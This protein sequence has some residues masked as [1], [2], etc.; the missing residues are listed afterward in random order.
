MQSLRPRMPTTPT[1]S[2]RAPLT[3]LKLQALAV[4]GAFGS[5][6]AALQGGA[7]ANPV[8][9]TVVNGQATFNAAGK[10]L[11]ITNTPGAVINWQSFSIGASE[12][13]KFQQQSA[14]SA[15]LNRVVG[16]D[17][18]S[19]L[20][21]LISNGKVFLINPNGIVFGQGARIDVAGLVAST[22]HISTE[23]FLNGKLK[24]QAG[25]VQGT[26][27]NQGSINAAPGGTI[28]LVGKDVSNSGIIQAPNGQIILAAGTT[29]EVIDT[30]T[31]GVKVVFTADANKAENLGT[32]TGQ[33]IN[34]AGALLRNKGIINANQ[35]SRDAQGRIVLSASKSVTLESGSTITANSQG[36][37]TAGGSIAIT[38]GNDI[39]VEGNTLT[40]A[41]GSAG[42]GGT[43]K[44]TT[45]ETGVKITV[46]AGALIQ[47]NGGA[48]ATASAG[49]PNSGQ[50]GGF[51]T[52]QATKGT[53]S[54]AGNLEARGVATPTTA[55]TTPGTAVGA[56]LGANLNDL[57][58]P[59]AGGTVQVLGQNVALSGNATVDASGTD[60][61]GTILIGGDYRGKNPEIQNAL[62]TLIDRN[63]ILKAD[64][65]LKGDGGKVI[66]WADNATY[67]TGSLLARG[68][69]EGGDGGFAEVSGK[70]FLYFSPRGSVDLSAPNGK[71][72]TLLLD[73][74]DITIVSGPLDIT[75]VS[76]PADINGDGSTG[77]DISS[78]TALNTSGA[79]G[80][81][82][83]V[84]TN[85]ALAGVLNNADVTLQASSNITVNAAINS[86]SGLSLTADRT[87]TL[88][89]NT[90]DLL[91]SISAAGSAY[92]L[93]LNFSANSSINITTGAQLLTNGGVV[94]I[95][96]GIGTFI[97]GGTINTGA[98]GG[99][100]NI[101]AD[102]AS[103]LSGSLLNTTGAGVFIQP[104]TAS[105]TINL[106]S[107]AGGL[108]LS[109]T[110][111]GTV[112]SASLTIG[113]T[114]QTGDINAKGA[115]TP[116]GLPALSLIQNPAAGGKIYL[117]DSGGS[118]ALNVSAANLV[119]SAGTGGIVANANNAVNELQTSGTV[120]MDTTGSMGTGTNQIQYSGSAT[121]GLITIGA[122]A[123]PSSVSMTG[124]A[125][126]LGNVTASGD[127]SIFASGNVIVSGNVNAGAGQISM[128]ADAETSPD[129]VGNFSLAA[130]K[131]ISTSNTTHVT[132]AAANFT[133][134][135]AVAVSISGADIDLQGAVAPGSG[136]DVSLLVSKAGRTVGLGAATGALSL[137][138]TELNNV[139][140][141][142]AAG[143]GFLRVGGF[144]SGAVNVSGVN[145]T[146]RMAIVSGSTIDD[147]GTGAAITSTS[148]LGLRSAG[149]IGAA[150][151]GSDGLTIA[152]PF[153][154][155]GN[156]GGADAA[157]THS[158]AGALT[159]RR[160]VTGGVGNITL[161]KPTGNISFVQD[162]GFT[163]TD[164][165]LTSGSLSISAAAGAITMT[166]M[167]ITAGSISLFASGSITGNSVLNT[168]AANG[169]IN[170]S[171]S[172]IGASGGA[173]RINV[174]PGT[175][176][177]RATSLS[178]GVSDGVFLNQTVGNLV[179]SRFNLD[180]AGTNPIEVST[181]GGNIVID[182]PFDGPTARP[183]TLEVGGSGSINFTPSGNNQVLASQLNLVGAGSGNTINFVSGTTT[184][185]TPVNTNLPI[186]LTGGATFA[187]GTSTLAGAISGTG[188][189]TIN[190]SGINV[191][192]TAGFSVGALN[193]SDGTINFGAGAPN[194]GSFTQTGGAITGSGVLSVGTAFNQTGGAISGPFSD[195]NILQAA[196]NLSVS[197]MSAVNTINLSA[198]SGAITDANG[199]GVNNLVAPT[200]NLKAATGIDIDT[201]ATTVNLSATA[202]STQNVRVPN[203]L[204][205]NAASTG[206]AINVS[207]TGA[208]AL[209]AVSTVGAL[210]LS[211]GTGITQTAPLSVASVNITGGAGVTLNNVGNAIGT[212][213]LSTG[214][215]VVALHSSTNITLAAL[216]GSASTATISSAGTISNSG[217]TTANG[218]V[219][220]SGTGVANSGII[221]GTGVQIS[222]GTGSLNT[223][224]INGTTGAVYL[225]G[226][227]LSIAGSIIAGSISGAAVTLAPFT[228]GTAVALGSGGGYMIPSAAFGSITGPLTIS[229]GGPISINSGIT[230][231]GSLKLNSPST[232]SIN[233]NVTASGVLNID[234]TT[235]G[236]TGAT[237]QG[238]SVALSASGS[239]ALTGS[240]SGPAGVV[241]TSGNIS[242]S[243]PGISYTA[244]SGNGAYINAVAG[245]AILTVDSC[246]GCTTLATNPTVSSVGSYASLG[247]TTVS[248]TPGTNAVASTTSSLINQTIAS[249]TTATTSTSTA[250]NTSTSASS[251]TISSTNLVSSSTTSSTSTTPFTTTSSGSAGDSFN[252]FVS[253]SGSTTTTSRTT[254]PSGS[255]TSTTGSTTT[256][257]SGTN[258]ATTDTTGGT[259]PGSTTGDDGTSSQQ[260][261]QGKPEEKPEAKPDAQPQTK[262]AAKPQPK[263]VLSC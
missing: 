178:T 243:A 226:D 43:I 247:V 197:A 144:T 29:V 22:S 263:K 261:P 187:T 121:P 222:S 223:G 45:T 64:A 19:I 102:N 160:L 95:N 115:A 245:S 127:V 210:N 68:G 142:G 183:I 262:P 260:Q 50:A 118:T 111:L 133:G 11:T 206:G 234:P 221:T 70:D 119:L 239:I 135:S 163:A 92:K 173:N 250:T 46:D 14:S 17:P 193:V 1:P 108:D 25:V 125:F 37:G 34:I 235:I 157:L 233:A 248:F 217:T 154:G 194:I 86:D 259:N 150:S 214:S 228:A 204:T 15:V 182:T 156:T 253:G 252:S 55:A 211:A 122:N 203:A 10:T 24:F 48:N 238:S 38:A 224:T 31:P 42:P 36:N 171:G 158:G 196:G 106:G 152:V 145:V 170:V 35:V 49:Q 225:V 249:T 40:Q 177:V 101:I 190:G 54:V 3:R 87:L 116:T 258:T 76:G 240:G 189:I 62:T 175:G 167:P 242:M 97:N 230:Y 129:G 218:L 60:G 85:A 236:I 113:A 166:A 105:R 51:I 255:T 7:L 74:L 107:G 140:V 66:V 168:S 134:L 220:F 209:G 4:A 109:N 27:V 181:S 207:A 241:A 5:L 212:A 174:N 88:Q 93:N 143:T 32:L 199:A 78:A 110:E 28:L 21:Q 58:A 69:R 9:P 100:I 81:V 94:T 153:L 246:I 99:N 67:F 198:T 71:R 61:G 188:T 179:G 136:G 104:F 18:S 130:G 2:A 216:S 244:G 256:S 132:D 12:I 180:P 77:D 155:I 126:A 41:N 30:T 47:A 90:I 128:G 184:F 213:T 141:S 57:P 229:T 114:G 257:T 231:G 137:S 159:V 96:A 13:T 6:A 138:N 123:A 201:T 124:P 237:I 79:F 165:V 202:A 91:N 56:T 208:V 59:A 52:L 251:S 98:G 117:D 232:I 227:S 191:A 219:V 254:S 73:P 33:N 147:V 149:A 185:N 72:G 112:V 120:S 215:G 192:P 65:D 53:T 80:A 23:D 148:G 161:T 169:T 164:V 89:A 39:K 162:A 172:T 176:L 63:V 16:A 205:L 139:A 146:A 131:S 84:I 26:V 8:A 103:L 151:G 75:I 200:V 195:I 186:N 20:G 83:S 44:L 82:S